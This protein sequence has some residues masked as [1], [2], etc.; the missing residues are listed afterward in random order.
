VL[1]SIITL[2]K[3]NLFKARLIITYGA[4]TL[5]NLLRKIKELQHKIK[6]IDIGIHEFLDREKI[7]RSF[8]K[9]PCFALSIKIRDVGS[10]YC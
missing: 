4:V 1:N 2:D 5:P 10:H 6:N 9:K 7:C 3:L 8:I